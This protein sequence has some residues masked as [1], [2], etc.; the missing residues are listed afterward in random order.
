MLLK[1]KKVKN[2]A[3]TD[4][5]YSILGNVIIQARTVLI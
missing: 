2:Q 4:V 5:K 3:S 1:C